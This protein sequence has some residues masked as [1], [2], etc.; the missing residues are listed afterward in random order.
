MSKRPRRSAT[1]ESLVE[2]GVIL[3]REVYFNV[4]LPEAASALSGGRDTAKA[5][6]HLTAYISHLREQAEDGVGKSAKEEAMP[7]PSGR[8]SKRKAG[9]ETPGSSASSSAGQGSSSQRG[10]SHGVERSTARRKLSPGATPQGTPATH[11]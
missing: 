8:G 5:E 6:K 2:H 3:D 4:V 9:E 11:G 1:A 7:K 10:S